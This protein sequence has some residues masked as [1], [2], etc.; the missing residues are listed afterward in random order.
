MF[1]VINTTHTLFQCVANTRT[2]TDPPCHALT[3]GHVWSISTSS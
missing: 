2:L 1:P 3:N